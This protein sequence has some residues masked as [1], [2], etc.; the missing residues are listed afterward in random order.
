MIACLTGALLY[1]DALELSCVVECH[2]VGYALSVTA[3]T[4]AKLPPADEEGANVVRLFTHMQISAQTSATEVTLYGFADREELE[5]FRLLITV[6]GVGPRAAMAILSLYD[7]QTLA[8]LIADEDTRSI[9]KASGVGSKI[10]ARVVLELADKV[11]KMFDLTA[12]PSVG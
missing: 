5:F 7:P 9:A 8:V 10:A 3:N 4:M 6:Q 12:A 2:G 1:A 11:R